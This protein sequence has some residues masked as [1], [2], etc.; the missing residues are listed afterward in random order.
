M[1]RLSLAV[2]CA[3]ALA[4]SPLAAQTTAA[5]GG[6]PS[7]I[8]SRLFLG[9]SLNGS[10]L[11]FD[12]DGSEAES[13]SGL[14]F[15][16]GWGF[17]PRFA[18]F[19]DLAGASMNAEGAQYGLGHVDIGA[20]YSFARP[21]TRW[22]PFLEAAFSGRA[23]VQEDVEVTDQNGNPYLADMALSGNG[24]TVGGG[25]QYYIAPTWA[26]STS[27]K[28]TRGEFST[29]EFDN[30]AVE[31]LELDATSARFNLGLTWHPLGGR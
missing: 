2:A 30:V 5:S 13:G 8:T 6:A 17:T 3:A 7:S 1:P 22:V 25:I 18:L 23:V 31:G 20:R 4:A 26:L 16:L 29:V 19:T 10:S 28:W 27:L 24:F 15:H 11:Q 9:V 12:E 21:T 14:G